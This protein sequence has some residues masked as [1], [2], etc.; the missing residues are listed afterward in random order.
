MHG[1]NASFPKAY[2]TLANQERTCG[3]MEKQKRKS[4]LD[5]VTLIS[6]DISKQSFAFQ[7]VKLRITQ[8]ILH[9]WCRISDP[10]TFS[11][12]HFQKYFFF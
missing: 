3:S 1:L 6:G 4:K 11:L 12:I 7:R 2:R 5:F 9:F 8:F 10:L